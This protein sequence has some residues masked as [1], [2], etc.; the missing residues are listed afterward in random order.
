VF[1]AYKIEIKKLVKNG[2][3]SAYFFTSLRHNCK[4][5]YWESQMECFNAIIMLLFSMMLAVFLLIWCRFFLILNGLV[6]Y[7]SKIY[8]L[9][10]FSSNVIT[11]NVI[12]RLLWF[13]TIYQ[14]SHNKINS[15]MLSFGQCD[16]DQIFTFTF[17]ITKEFSIYFPTGIC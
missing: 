1:W 7:F 17:W 3:N 13:C 10:Y 8:W 5:T 14:I 12:A 6:S 9:Y 11:V 16:R 4:K 2:I 15:L